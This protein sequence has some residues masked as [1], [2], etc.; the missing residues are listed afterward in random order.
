MQRFGEKLRILRQRS[1]LSIRELAR[2]LG[3]QG[4]GYLHAI[5]TGKITPRVDFMLKV[6]QRFGVPLDLLA[7]DDLHLPDEAPREQPE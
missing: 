7:R 1:D 6:S 3:Y 2:E 5:E 4:S